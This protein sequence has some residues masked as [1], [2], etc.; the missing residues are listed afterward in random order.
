[1]GCAALQAALGEGDCFVVGCDLPF[2]DEKL[3]QQIC[4]TQGQAVVPRVDGRP[5]P[6]HAYYAASALPIVSA[7]LR[8]GKLRLVEL[9]DELEVRYLDV[10]PQRGLTNVNTPDDLTALRR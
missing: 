7:R 2:L 1:L 10:P 3:I 8:D 5:Q 6:L 4:G 9:L